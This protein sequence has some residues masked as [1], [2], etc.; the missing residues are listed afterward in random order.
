MQARSTAM[1]LAAPRESLFADKLS[2]CRKLL[3]ALKALANT[4]VCAQG[5]SRTATPPQHK[6]HW[7]T[8]PQIHTLPPSYV[9][10]TIAVS[11]A[12]PSRSL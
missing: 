3:I 11:T 10:L 8:C 7:S 4:Q 12:P 1:G 6:C 2:T 5:S 9:S